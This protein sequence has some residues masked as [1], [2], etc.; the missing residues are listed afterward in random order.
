MSALTALSAL[1]KK[2]LPTLDYLQWD[3]LPWIS[4]LQLDYLRWII[5]KVY[6]NQEMETY[7]VELI[8]TID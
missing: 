1:S 5:S 3:Y 7:K 2:C 4:Y 8:S 6:R